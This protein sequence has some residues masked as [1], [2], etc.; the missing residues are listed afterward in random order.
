MG[1]LSLIFAAWAWSVSSAHASPV[2]EEI[3]ASLES[4]LGECVSQNLGPVT[5]AV[6]TLRTKGTIG[7][8]VDYGDLA[9]VCEVTCGTGGCDIKIFVTIGSR[10][11]EMWEGLGGLRIQDG[12]I[13]VQRHGRF[14]GDEGPNWCWYSITLKRNGMSMELQ[15]R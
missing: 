14:C 13:L 1:L 15:G 3:I 11:H 12:R 10:T 7:Y 4:D 2:P 6:R 9:D 5:K 8:V